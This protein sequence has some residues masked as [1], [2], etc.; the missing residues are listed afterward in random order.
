MA[1]VSMLV[2]AMSNSN[3]ASLSAS[4]PA[5]A[6][7]RPL[8]V[9][10][11][12]TQPVKRFSR[13]QVDCL[14]VPRSHAVVGL[15]APSQGGGARAR[16]HPWRIITTVWNPREVEAAADAMARRPASIRSAEW[17]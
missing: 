2:K 8:S 10:V 3:P 11:T 4:P 1:R 14:R 13:F 5:D 9:S 17:S 15:I 6:S 7:A 12:S 16:S